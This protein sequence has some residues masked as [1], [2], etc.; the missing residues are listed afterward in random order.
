MKP[1]TPL[2]SV[3]TARPQPTPAAGIST[4]RGRRRRWIVAL[5][6]LLGLGA[7]N[8]FAQDAVTDADDLKARVEELERTNRELIRAL[9]DQ[10]VLEIDTPT[11]D[12]S[13]TGEEG[14]QYYPIA[15][16]PKESKPDGDKSSD[17]KAAKPEDEWYEVGSDLTMSASWNN[18]L[19][20]ATKNKDFRVHVGG[21]TQFDSSWFAVPENVNDDPSLRN[22]IHDGV[23]FRRARL[24]VDGTMW[25][26][27][28]WA[29]E[30]DFVNSAG[31]SPAFPGVTN[32][33]SLVAPTDLW[34]TFTK[35]PVVGNMRVGNQKEPIGFEHLTSSRFL[36]F[37]ERSF[38]QDAFYGG[39]VN[40]FSPGV[41]FFDTAFD[42]RTT[43]AVGVFKPGN[44]LFASSAENGVY[45]IT[46]RLTW[47]PW[48]VDD[49]RGLLHLGA[50]ARQ[51][52]MENSTYRWR[53]RGPERAGLSAL[54]PLYAD[55]GIIEGDNM[56][57]YNFEM[58]SVL[59]PWTFTAEY[60]FNPIHNAA[61]YL[62][63]TVGTVMYHGGYVEVLYFL[64]GEFRE[65]RRAGGVFERVIPHENAFFANS[66][67]GTTG[68]LGAWQ[69]GFRYNYLDLNDKGLNG[70][71]LNDYTAGLNWFL[72][73]N[74]KVQ[75][76]YSITDRQSIV[77]KYDGVIQGFGM[78]LAHDF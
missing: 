43:W 21:R 58:A 78:R 65:Y 29:A 26:Q 42:E 30:F 59:G 64:T 10:Q 17:K 22:P 45:S 67:D 14:L 34:W 33:T 57:Q 3:A 48:Y 15:D 18:G 56:Q 75:F 76:N 66:G 50:S 55:T 72:N 13:E 70:G 40:G 47:L 54:W 73:P 53:T 69:I 24:R 23:D 16:K 6:C 62:K 63:P 2:M 46:G 31:A 32:A 9:K 38:N 4:A 49:G 71:I 28:E 1:Q 61:S 39:F 41:Q 52:G 77:A 11:E 12:D 7:E 37:M 19:E 8:L 68:G 51:A 44:N 25:E 60:L 35:L 74:M 20:L 27:I 5:A 36:N